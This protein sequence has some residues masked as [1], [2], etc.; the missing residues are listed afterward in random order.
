MVKKIV[1][2]ISF[3]LYFNLIP[4]DIFIRKIFP[5]A[6]ELDYKSFLLLNNPPLSDNLKERYKELIR[7]KNL[8]L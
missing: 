7:I 5:Y 6:I 1:E 8:S 3:Q 4:L 2:K